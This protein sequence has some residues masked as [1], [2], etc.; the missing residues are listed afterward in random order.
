MIGAG[1]TYR[2]LQDLTAANGTIGQCK[3]DNL[4]IRRELDVL[5]NDQGSV[6]SALHL[7]LQDNDHTHM[8]PA[9]D[10]HAYSHHHI[11]H[12]GQRQRTYPL[13]PD[14]V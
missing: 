3:V 14:T 12:R 9:Y 8:R 7:Y 5:E 4:V 11:P 13:T 6:L 1:M 10:P 2:D